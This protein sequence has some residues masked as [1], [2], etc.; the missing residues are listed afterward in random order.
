MKNTDIPEEAKCTDQYDCVLLSSRYSYES[1]IVRLA[2]VEKGL[3]WKNYEV[4]TVNKMVNLENWYVFLNQSTQVPTMLVGENNDS[5]CN[6]IE[7]LKTIDQDFNG[8]TTLMPSYDMED[9][10]YQ[11]FKKFIEIHEQWDV[12]TFTLG[13]INNNM[14]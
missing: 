3:K 5:F 13:T 7:I 11:R 10:I 6:T 4:D 14:L 12:E 8:K 9:E 2:A 1:M